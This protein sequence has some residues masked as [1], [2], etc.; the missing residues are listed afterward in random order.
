MFKKCMCLHLVAQVTAKMTA[1]VRAE[2][3]RSNL[4]HM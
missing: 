1:L 3:E 4:K 2:V